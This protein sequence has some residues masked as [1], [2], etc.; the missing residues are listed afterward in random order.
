MKLSVSMLMKIWTWIPNINPGPTAKPNWTSSG[1]NA[2][3]MICCYWSSQGRSWTMP[4]KL[5][6]NVTMGVCAVPPNTKVRMF[7]RFI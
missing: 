5:W 4:V 6:K 1:V 7:F 3:K 2:S